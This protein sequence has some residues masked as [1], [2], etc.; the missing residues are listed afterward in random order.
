M[1]QAMYVWA[2]YGVAAVLLIGLLVAS[3]FGLRAR[4]AELDAA[5]DGRRRRNRS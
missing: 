2:S 3:W 1:T 5:G 4:E